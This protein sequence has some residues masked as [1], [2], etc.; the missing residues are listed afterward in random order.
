[1]A[2]RVSH[3]PSLD[4]TFTR[5]I[6]SFDL[7]RVQIQFRFDVPDFR[8]EITDPRA[9]AG[10]APRFP[11][12]ASTPVGFLKVDAIGAD[13]ATVDR[14]T[15]TLAVDEDAIPDGVSIDD[16]TAYQY[17]DDEWRSL[18]TDTSGG[19]LTATLATHEA[20]HIALAVESETDTAEA[21][22]DSG[23]YLR[24]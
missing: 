23:L 7:T 16:L 18:A 13:Q 15:A 10:P 3:R 17:V 12:A 14:T 19:T 11:D 4:G 1:M 22:D 2:F 5:R 9:E 21:S 24:T 6:C 8:I 20:E